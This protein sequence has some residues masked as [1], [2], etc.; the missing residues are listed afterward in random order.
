MKKVVLIGCFALLVSGCAQRGSHVTITGIQPGERYLF[1]MDQAEAVLKN[2]PMNH[3]RDEARLRRG[4]D[5]EP[6]W[7]K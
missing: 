3:P 4:R 1:Q 5:A 2:I 6:D 7:L